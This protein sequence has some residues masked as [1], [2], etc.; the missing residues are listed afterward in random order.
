[1]VPSSIARNDFCIRA[2]AAQSASVASGIQGGSSS[3]AARKRS[4]RVAIATAADAAPIECP[5]ATG[6][7]M[8]S[9]STRAMR[10]LPPSPH[11]SEESER[12]WL[13]AS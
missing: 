3:T 7:S 2:R 9:A 6:P 11:S 5:I 13:R 1:L 8:P 12:P 4:G 10:S